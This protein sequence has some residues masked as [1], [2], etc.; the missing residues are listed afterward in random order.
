MKKVRVSNG[1]QT[2]IVQKAMIPF[3]FE[4]IGDHK[5]PVPYDQ[6]TEEQLQKVK[7]DD[8]KAFLDAE[9]VDYKSDATKED[10]IKAIKE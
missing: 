5:E 8:L 2:L 6:K 1:K 7:N 9:G 10:L 3:G 4:V